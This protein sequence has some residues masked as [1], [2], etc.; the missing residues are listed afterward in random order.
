MAIVVS[1]VAPG[2][3]ADWYG[4]VSGRAMPG[5][6]LP[7]GCELHIAGPVDQGWRVITVWESQEAFDR[8]RDEKFLPAVREVGGGEDPPDVRPE[9]GPV[10]TLI[11]R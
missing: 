9:I 4:A 1:A 7:E 5:N 11:A 6:Q 8:F 3:T 10:H 2:F